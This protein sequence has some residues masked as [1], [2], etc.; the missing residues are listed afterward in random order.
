M[1]LRKGNGGGGKGFLGTGGNRMGMGAEGLC[2]HWSFLFLFLVLVLYA[3][4]SFMR[5]WD[6][7]LTGVFFFRP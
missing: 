4:L 3:K 1:V 5:I 6:S 7:G 2:K